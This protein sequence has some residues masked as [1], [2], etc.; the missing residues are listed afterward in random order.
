MAPCSLWSGNSGFS[1]GAGSVFKRP[2][3]PACLDLCPESVWTTK[4]LWGNSLLFIY[5]FPFSTFRPVWVLSFQRFVC[6]MFWWD[7][8]GEA[9]GSLVAAACFL[10]PAHLLSWVFNRHPSS[11]L[12]PTCPVW[13]DPPALISLYFCYLFTPFFGLKMLTLAFHRLR[14]PLLTTSLSIFS[15]F[16]VI[17]QTRRSIVYPQI[18][19]KKNCPQPGGLNQC[20]NMCVCVCL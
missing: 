1:G 8:F 6:L 14:F 9:A 16:G 5:V 2:P 19:Y 3:P 10:S 11:Q 12:L 17:P 15:L 18:N 20:I 7:C 4:L 13:V